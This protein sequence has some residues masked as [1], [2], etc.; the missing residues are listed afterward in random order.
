MTFVKT[1]NLKLICHRWALCDHAIACPLTGCHSKPILIRSWDEP[2]LLFLTCANGVKS[3]VARECGNH[4]WFFAYLLEQGGL[5]GN[6]NIIQ[7]RIQLLKTQ[8]GLNGSERRTCG[9][10]AIHMCSRKDLCFLGL[11]RILLM[12]TITG[13]SCSS[14]NVNCHSVGPFSLLFSFWCLSLS[15]KYNTMFIYRTYFT[16]L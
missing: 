13:L 9:D 4:L 8:K 12:W 1:Q 11:A 2:D 7:Y 10:V 16:T 14:G 3:K 15:F 5:G 6:Y